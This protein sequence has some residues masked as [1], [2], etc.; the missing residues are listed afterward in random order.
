M[1][2]VAKLHPQVQ[3][4]ISGY[5]NSAPQENGSQYACCL[6]PITLNYS[7]KMFLDMVEGLSRDFLLRKSYKKGKS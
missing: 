5:I 4:W 2:E 7:I 1:L 3:A 6:E